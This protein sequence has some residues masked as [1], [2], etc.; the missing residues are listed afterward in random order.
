MMLTASL[1][2]VILVCIRT[3]YKTS[4]LRKLP[5]EIFV[6]ADN[7]L[8]ERYSLGNDLNA[9]GSRFYNVAAGRNFY[10]GVS[11][12]LLPHAKRI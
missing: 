1:L 2:L 3:G 11:V 6:G 7:L 8:D 4:F 10:G 5:V 12:N 9:T